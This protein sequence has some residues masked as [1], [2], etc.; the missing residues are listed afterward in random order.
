MTPVTF[1][2]QNNEFKKP[3]DL[4]DDQCASLPVWQGAIQFPDGLKLPAIV[5]CWRLSEEE[6]EEIKRTGVVWL[7][8][9][10][11]GTP[12]VC[13]FAENPLKNAQSTQ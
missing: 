1:P 5:S 6:L 11:T 10:G 2:E 8:V 9:I 13:V 12:P 7:S 3:S 4:T